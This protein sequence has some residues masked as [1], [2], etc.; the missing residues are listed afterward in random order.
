MQ[1]ASNPP[2]VHLFR[3]R[4]APIFEYLHI[5]EEQ[6]DGVVGLVQLP[7]HFCCVLSWFPR[8]Q[9]T[10]VLQGGQS[11]FFYFS[12]AFHDIVGG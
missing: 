8:F 4:V 12:V 11:I 7:L 5:V 6:A 9:E 3:L 2:A 1:D 10:D